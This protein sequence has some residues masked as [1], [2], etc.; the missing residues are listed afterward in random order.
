MAKT[1][2]TDLPLLMAIEPQD[3]HMII[4]KVPY[5]AEDGT[6]K[7]YTYSRQ[8]SSRTVARYA[9]PPVSLASESSSI[10]AT[11]GGF[12]VEAAQS[13]AVVQL[14]PLADL[15]R[16]SA[17]V[18]NASPFDLEVK[19]AGES[20]PFRLPGKDPA[21]SFIVPPWGAVEFRPI[22][23][24]DPARQGWMP[25]AS[26]P[27]AVASVAGRMGDV[28]IFPAD[29]IGL[30][31]AATHAAADFA[32]A[33]QGAKADSAVQPAGLAPYAT[34]AATTDAISAATAPI[35]ASLGSHAA[36]ADNPHGVTKSQ[37]GLANA[38][39]TSDANKPV[40]TATAAAINA[41]ANRSD[42]PHGVTKA[43]VGLGSV[44]NTSDLAKP[45]GTA[46]QAALDVKAAASHGHAIADV[47]GLQSAL[48]AKLAINGNGS[49]LAGLTAAQ[50]G[51]GNADNTSDAA[52]PISTATAAALAGKAPTA[53]S[54]AVGDVAGLQAAL[55][56]KAA[57]SHAHTIAN[58]TGLQASLDG[59][60]TSAQGAKADSATQ[61]ADLSAGLATRA[62]LAHTHAAADIT[63]GT[64]AP[65]RLATGTPAA[66]KY[67]DGAG[68][69]TT[70]PS[71]A[72][73][74][75]VAASAGLIGLGLSQVIDVTWPTAFA[76]ANYTPH[77][78]ISPATGN[79]AGLTVM[80][81]PNWTAATCKFAVTN[82]GITLSPA[83]TL[84]ASAIHD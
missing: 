81:L 23:T 75:R 2:V 50:V 60:A 55:D 45:I 71:N 31:T 35:S 63:S 12:I 43:Q 33:A 9:I 28:T 66:G 17:P 42:N 1:K 8:S 51:L 5:T 56:G 53:H 80:V 54:H 16:Q 4:K 40:S 72:R 69:W 11:S 38:D 41:H 46:T 70:L 10:T 36:R 52:K 78:N 6:T 73:T 58:I 74:K 34:T 26:M 64:L 57:A 24:S 49:A 47:G 15:F 83:F 20:E 22:M 44:D 21:T 18:V 39:N 27:D 19:S 79:T 48:D 30:G 76:D 7:F 77:A 3:M 65:A 25:R 59:K 68:A 37:V 82:T 67:P 13:G 61:P 29:V 14:P 32:S 62:A 84:L